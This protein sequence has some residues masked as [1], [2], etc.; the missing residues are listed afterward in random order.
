M[1]AVH[2]Q[3]DMDQDV[4]VGVVKQVLLDEASRAVSVGVLQVKLAE[5]PVGVAL[6]RNSA[7][8]DDLLY[9]A[10]YGKRK[11]IRLQKPL[12]E[13]LSIQS[14]KGPAREPS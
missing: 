5:D 1:F 9:S 3:E 6:Q 8:E 10:R 14:E 4:E 13:A 2:H 12:G 7:S 11:P